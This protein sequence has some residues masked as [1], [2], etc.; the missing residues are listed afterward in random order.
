MKCRFVTLSSELSPSD[1]RTLI[2]RTNYHTLF[3]DDFY[4]IKDTEYRKYRCAWVAHSTCIHEFILSLSSYRRLNDC[5]G[6]CPQFTF[7]R[8]SFTRISCHDFRTLGFQANL[9]TFIQLFSNLRWKQSPNPQNPCAH[10]L[11]FFL[12][13]ECPP[14]S[15]ACCDHN[16]KKNRLPLIFIGFMERE[17]GG[18]PRVLSSDRASL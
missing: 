3:Y 10:S 9:R 11:S 5:C 15:S 13:A 18:N 8:H 17:E 12:I 4:D 1:S 2:Y 14:L 6:E 7:D 16:E